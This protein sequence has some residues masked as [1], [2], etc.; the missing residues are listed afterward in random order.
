[1]TAPIVSYGGTRFVDYFAICGLDIDSG[2][3]PDRLSGNKHVFNAIHTSIN[4]ILLVDF[5]LCIYVSNAFRKW[6]NFVAW[7]LRSFIEFS[8]IRHAI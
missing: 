7:H 6:L 5:I 8:Q 2:L 4:I 1:M 3:E